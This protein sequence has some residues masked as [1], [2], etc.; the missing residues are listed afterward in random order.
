MNEVLYYYSII[1]CMQNI[2]L[3]KIL[4]Q[5]NNKIKIA[6]IVNT[7]NTTTTDS[8]ASIIMVHAGIISSLENTVMDKHDAY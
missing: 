4:R 1:P 2:P 7:I 8:T 5:M 3:F 6:M